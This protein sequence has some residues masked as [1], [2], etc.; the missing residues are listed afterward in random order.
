MLAE[1]WYNAFVFPWVSSEDIFDHNDR[2]L[3]HV[4]DFRLNKIKQSLYAIVCRG[5]YFDGKTANRTHSLPNEI[6]VYFGSIPTTRHLRANGKIR[7]NT[8]YSCSSASTSRA[9]SSRA[10]RYMIS[11]FASFTYIG[12]LYL[13]KNTLT[14]FF[15]TEGLRWMMRRIF[16]NATYWTSGPDESNVTVGRK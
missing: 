15:S 16:R 11:S 13:Q 14:S 2:L 6:N 10:N 4:R 5:L 8:T 9:F 3:H 1:L 7:K 12:S